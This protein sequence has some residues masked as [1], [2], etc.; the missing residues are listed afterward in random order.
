[1]IS[2]KKAFPAAAVGALSLSIFGSTTFSAPAQEL[3]YYEKGNGGLS[4]ELVGR[5]TSGA[6]ID[7]GGTEIVAYD[8]RTYRAFSV[9][10]AEKAIDILDLSQLESGN[11]EIP[12]SKRILLK[13]LGV[14]ASDVTSIAVHPKGG[15][16]AVTAPAVGKEQPGHVVFMTV[17]GKALANVQV[18]ALPDM[19]TFTP[20]GSKI[21]VANEGEPKE[22]YSVNPEG[23]VSVIDLP[24]QIEDIAQ[25]NVANVRFTEDVIDEDVRKVHPES[26]YAQDLEPEYITTDSSG[27]FAYVA[28]QENNAMAK[29]DIEA[30]EFISVQSLGYKDFTAP[31][32]KFDASNKDDATDIRNWP[33][34]SMYQP[35]GITSFESNGET[36]ILSANEGDAQ[37]WEGFSEEARVA[38]LKGQYELNADLYVGINQ[39]RLAK[40]TANGLFEENQLGRLTTS[41][42]HP[43]NEEG[44][45]E[46]IYGFGG[47]SFSVWHADSMELAY[48]SGDDFEQIIKKTDPEYF[49][50]TN[51][52]DKADNRSDDKGPEP[53]SVITGNVQGKDYAFIGLER[54]GGIMVYDLSKPAK[55]KFST[56]FSSRIFN[57]GDVTEASGDVA[58]EGLT[59]IPADQSPTGK[60]LLLA[61]HEVS[62]TI[63]AYELGG[64]DKKDKRPEHAKVKGKSFVSAR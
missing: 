36:Y 22:D 37:D 39:K 26:T 46:A 40:L 6:E 1:M 21:L 35:D 4:V 34:L 7:E 42:S 47:R 12:L 52:E 55:P 51:D 31:K 43:K 57:G 5:Y 30:K 63:A 58:P 19:L 27:Q 45:Y 61:A 9:N 8:S 20:D 29:L 14:E 16:I 23:S 44:K 24:A 60:E 17:D 41:I 25:T 10:G 62:G 53:E 64:E 18:G 32:N 54:Q 49:N 15:Y 59:F 28:L 3:N 13:D 2:F 56:Y 38:D 33:V 11:A 48:D 50:T